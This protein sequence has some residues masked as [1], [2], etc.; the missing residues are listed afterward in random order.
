MEKYLFVIDYQKDFVDGARA[1]PGRRSWMA[2]LRKK[3][4]PTAPAGSSSP[5]TPTFPTT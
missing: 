4:A 2:L 1:F 3:S 5:G